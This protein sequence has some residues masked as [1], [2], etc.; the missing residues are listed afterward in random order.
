MILRIWTGRVR[1]SDA[2][3]YARYVSD[4]GIR[5]LLSTKGNR[6]A[7]LC[8][9]TDGDAEEITVLSLWDGS[10]SIRAFAGED[11]ERARYYPQDEAYLIEQPLLVQH[12]EVT[13]G[14]VGGRTE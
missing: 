1:S 4:T 3:V 8:R 7:L 9:R 5:E 11:Y 12:F 14:T 2:E 13:D 10:E 6:G